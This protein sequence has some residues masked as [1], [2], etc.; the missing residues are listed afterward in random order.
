MAICGFVL[1]TIA[2]FFALDSRSAELRAAVHRQIEEDVAQESRVACEK[3][4]MEAATA[5]Q[6][7]CV[8]DLAA[9]RGNHDNRRRTDDFGF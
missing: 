7:A 6:I 9:I 8:A 3:W 5:A 1:G 2:F 4:G